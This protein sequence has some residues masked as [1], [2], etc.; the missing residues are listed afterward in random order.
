[1][2]LTNIEAVNIMIG[3]KEG[4]AFYPLF[5]DD[6]ITYFLSLNGDSVL[7][8]A[9]MASTFAAAQIAGL[10]TREV[11]GDV[12]FWNEAAKRYIEASKLLISMI[13]NTAMLNAMPY[14][15]GLT[16][17]DVAKYKNN[18]DLI[19]VNIV[20]GDPYPTLE[21]LYSNSYSYPPLVW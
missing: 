6:E 11:Y 18:T 4:M 1:M 3:N 20:S 21:Y 14:S 5:T 7:P 16:K 15:A 19:L 13:E 12:E 10:N 2:A 8:T 9:K 17:T